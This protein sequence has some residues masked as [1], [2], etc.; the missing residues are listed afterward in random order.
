[1]GNSKTD[2]GEDFIASGMTLIT[3]PRSDF[4]LKEDQKK[5]LLK[6]VVNDPGKECDTDNLDK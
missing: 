1:M 5:K 4:Y 6:E 3:D 2:L